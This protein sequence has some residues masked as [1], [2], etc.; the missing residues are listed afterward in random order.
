MSKGSH[1]PRSRFVTAI[2]SLKKERLSRLARRINSAHAAAEDASRKVVEHAVEAGRL[3]IEAK[4]ALPHGS[5]YPWLKANVYVTPRSC[6][7][8]MRLAK[9]IRDMPESKR[10]HVSDLPLR[11]ALRV[12]G[13]SGKPGPQ[14][15]GYEDW[16]TPAALVERVRLVLRTIDLDPASNRK[17]QEIIKAK[18]YYTMSDDGLNHKWSGQV[19]MNPPYSR[20]KVSAFTNKLGLEY[21]AGN[22]TEAICLV[23]AYTDAQWFQRLAA[24]SAA[25]CFPKSRVKFIAPKNRI[26]QPTQGQAFM[27]LGRRVARFQKHFTDVGTIVVPIR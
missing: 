9:V 19:W 5:W 24:C 1:Q 2:V 15:T 17:A 7:Y 20:D 25:I 13:G 12:I 21:V 23:S 27:Y 8:Y 18:R 16:H 10:K 4:A 3:L 14:F 22:V 6:R 26:A 11:E